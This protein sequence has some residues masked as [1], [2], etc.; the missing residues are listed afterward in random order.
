MKIGETGIW[1]NANASDHRCDMGLAAAIG[2]FLR[3][4]SGVAVVDIGC[5]A[6][7]YVRALR[8]MGIACDGY[9][10]APNTEALTGGL[11]GVLDFA[12]RVKLACRYDWALSLEVGEH[13]PKALEHN[14]IRNLHRNNRRGI[15]L[16]WAAPGQG[17]VGHVNE[18]SN[19]HIKGI[20]EWMGYRNNLE[21][22][23][24][25]RAA[26][27]DCWW[28]RNTVMVFESPEWM[29]KNVEF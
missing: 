5:G 17:G 27:T 15:I 1:L 25:L 7:G 23:G 10:G 16:S 14:F 19:E 8:G 26:V 2:E 12:L 3:E 28:L 21:A 24:R 18:R 4:E 20:F 6:G 11:C 22:E 29:A 13:I 9:D